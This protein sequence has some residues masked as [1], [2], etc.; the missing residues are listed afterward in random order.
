MRAGPPSRWARIQVPAWLCQ[1]SGHPAP[2][3]RFPPPPDGPR[4][5]V[6]SG[7]PPS[8]P[9]RS[10][11]L[12]NPAAQPEITVPTTLSLCNRLPAVTYPLWVPASGS[13]PPT[14]GPQGQI[15]YPEAPTPRKAP[16]P[17]GAASRMGPWA[18]G[19]LCQPPFCPSAGRL[20]L[21]AL[22]LQ[23]EM[24]RQ[25]AKGKGQET[26][27]QMERRWR[28]E[29]APCSAGL[30]EQPAG[31]ETAEEHPPP[32]PRPWPGGNAGTCRDISEDSPQPAAQSAIITATVLGGLCPCCRWGS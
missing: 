4:Q 13:L 25:R 32:R 7:C 18:A 10:A 14:L 16:P 30:W 9:R 28:G 22:C 2:K 15:S 3:P 20:L 31:T 29:Q 5:V 23:L 11:P 1:A 26:P 27:L 6:A 24:R 21:P 8:S 12:H 17:H 19:G